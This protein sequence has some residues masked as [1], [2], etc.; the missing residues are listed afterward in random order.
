MLLAAVVFSALFMGPC[1]AL[2]Q[3]FKAIVTALQKRGDLG[4]TLLDHGFAIAISVATLGCLWGI[5]ERK[6]KA[7]AAAYY[8]SKQFS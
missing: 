4:V 6:T 7:L 3:P 8:Y 2:T 5:W 1:G